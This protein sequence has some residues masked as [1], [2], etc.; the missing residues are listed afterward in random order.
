MAPP[1]PP[2]TESF[3]KTIMIS[4]CEGLRLAAATAKTLEVLMHTS[5]AIPEQLKV[6]SNAVF[7]ETG[8]AD[9]G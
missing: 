3:T 4:R 7:F 8:G 9:S 6:E 2:Y 1:E 5:L